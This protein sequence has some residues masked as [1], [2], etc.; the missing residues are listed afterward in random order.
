S[1]AVRGYK[2]TRT[3]M[4]IHLVAFYGLALPLGC[5]LG[6]AP[7]WLPWKPAVAMGAEGFWI[8]LILGLTVAGGLLLAYLQRISSQRI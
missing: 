7:D 1:C 2:V 8:G 5:A 6:L 3:P 4:I